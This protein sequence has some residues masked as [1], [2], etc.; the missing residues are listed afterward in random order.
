MNRFQ[1]FAA[2]DWSGAKG[3]RHKGIAVA[4]CDSGDATPRLVERHRPWS[5]TEVLEWLLETASETP[6]LYGFDFSYAPPIVER[7][8]YLPG[9]A[10]PEEI[11]RASCRA[12]V[13][14]YVSISGVA[15]SI[16]KKNT[17][18]KL[19]ET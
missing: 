19:K 8:A 10:A 9:E 15:V 5:R 2:I 1:C 16:K 11:G 7:G 14:Q 13:C 3:R 17:Q 12:R 6:T 4:I 18:R